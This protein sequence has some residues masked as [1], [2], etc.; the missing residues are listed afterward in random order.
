MART[1]NGTS[2]WGSS[3]TAAVTACPLTMAWYGKPSSVAAG[4]K[5]LFCLL[6]PTTTST[7]SFRLNQNG[8]TAF[9]A[10]Q[11]GNS[12]NGIA[13]AGTPGTSAYQSVVGVFTSN[14]SRTCYVDGV[15]GS[16]DTTA[17]TP[18]NVPTA[19]RVGRY[20]TATPNFWGGD[21]EY[22]AL[23]NIALSADDCAMLAAGVFPLLVRPDALTRLDWMVGP[24]ATADRDLIG[25][26]A[27]QL[28]Y[29]GT[30][31]VGGPVIYMPR[32][33][34]VPCP[35]AAAP[36]GTAVP[37]FVHHYRQQGAA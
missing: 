18:N 22:T 17:I 30:T 15:A 34:Y 3:S 27:G 10:I 2:D 37:V 1:F 26:V 23:W 8:S 12:V 4:S 33:L 20:D 25:G 19:T 16:T 35:A 14:S 9:R 13:T 31:I 11:M 29:I 21:A 36:S 28:G 24:G 32:G 6:G 7:N 5:E